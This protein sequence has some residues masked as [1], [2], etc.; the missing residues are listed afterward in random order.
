MSKDAFDPL[1]LNA[2]KSQS[3][4]FPVIGSAFGDVI[5]QTH[6]IDAAKL[7]K[8]LLDIATPRLIDPVY[9][10]RRYGTYIFERAQ[11]EDRSAASLKDED[12]DRDEVLRA[13]GN[14]ARS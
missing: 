10:A 11:Y 14:I 8:H 7:E 4:S 5:S 3:S 9:L 13:Y 6:S 2:P 12:A 1:T